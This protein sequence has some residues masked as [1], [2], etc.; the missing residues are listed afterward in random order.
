MRLTSLN[1]SDIGCSTCVAVIDSRNE[2]SG[3]DEETGRGRSNVDFLRMN[4]G[5]LIAR[6]IGWLRGVL[7]NAV[8]LKGLAVYF[9]SCCICHGCDGGE[10]FLANLKG[11]AGKADSV[12]IVVNLATRPLIWIR[13]DR[14]VPTP[15][16]VDR[17]CENVVAYIQGSGTQRRDD[18]GGASIVKKDQ[19]GCSAIGFE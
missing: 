3:I 7:E 18:A 11:F 9:V 6:C 2:H 1:G 4:K 14:R 15:R 17:A 8:V 10:V 16:G 5:L 19:P 13:G 12:R